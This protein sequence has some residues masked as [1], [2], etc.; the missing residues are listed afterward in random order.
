M[1]ANSEKQT[2]VEAWIKEHYPNVWS[3]MEALGYYKTQDGFGYRQYYINRDLD[4]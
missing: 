4:P 1:T 3:E 2:H